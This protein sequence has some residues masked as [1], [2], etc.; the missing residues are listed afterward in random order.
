MLNAGHTAPAIAGL[1]GERPVLLAFFKVSCPTCQFT[2][3]YLERMSGKIPVV[4]ISQ[5]N[6]EL[7]DEF[8]RAFRLT[9][10]ILI[11]GRGYPASNAYRIRTVP[12]LFLVEPDGRISL[13]V[14]GFSRA[15]LASIGER[16][17]A[18][19]FRDDERVPEFKPG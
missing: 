7:T 4:G 16:F 1:P 17:G 5:N 8:R 13:A 9:F 2:F 19:P 14:T 15:D 11:D 3:P 6:T 18:A 12:S 10:P